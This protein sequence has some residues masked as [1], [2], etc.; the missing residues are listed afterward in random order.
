MKRTGFAVAL[1]LLSK[2][3]FAGERKKSVKFYCLCN[4]RTVSL[5]DFD[6]EKIKNAFCLQVEC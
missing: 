3:L 6:L 2:K 5:A 1:A 4:I